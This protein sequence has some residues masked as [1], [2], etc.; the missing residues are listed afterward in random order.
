VTL[1]C[2]LHVLLGL[3]EHRNYEWF[4]T[5][6][7][8]EGIFCLVYIIDSMIV[9]TFIGKQRW[10]KHDSWIFILAILMLIDIVVCTF[11]PSIHYPFLRFLRPAFFAA[12]RRHI[13]SC[14]SSMV[15]AGFE[16]MPLLGILTFLVITFAVIGWITFDST[17][18]PYTDL[19]HDSN[20]TNLCYTANHG[21]GNTML[22]NHT[23]VTG[24]CND[25]FLTMSSSLYQVWILLMKVNMPDIMTPYYHVS[26]SSSSYFVVFTVFTQFFFL[27]LILAA[28]FT[29]YK[30]DYE[31]R[32]RRRLA[33]KNVAILKAFTLLSKHSHVEQPY[34]ATPGQNMRKKGSTTSPPANA[35]GQTPD[36]TEL[37]V[38]AESPEVVTKEET[39]IVKQPRGRRGLK[40]LS[41]MLL[42][43]PSLHSIDDY[44]DTSFIS[45][46]AWITTMEII[47][48][49]LKGFPWIYVLMF[50]SALTD[51][52]NIDHRET[53]NFK[54]FCEACHSI[55]LKVKKTIVASSTRHKS[56]KIIVLT[57]FG[58]FLLQCRKVCSHLVSKTSFEVVIQ[59]L[60]A[61]LGIATIICNSSKTSASDQVVRALEGA[62]C[63]LFFTSVMVRCIGHSKFWSSRTNKF[64]FLLMLTICSFFCIG[65]LGLFTNELTRENFNST[66]SLL[67]LL[68]V[69]RTITF[70]KFHPDVMSTITTIKVRET[71]PRFTQGAGL[72]TNFFT[73]PPTMQLILPMLARIGVVFM[74]VMYAFIMVGTSLFENSLV[75][76]PILDDTPYSQF[77]YD[78]LNFS[79]FL[80]TL[81]LLHQCLLGPNF[82]VFVEATALANG[83]WTFPLIY[84]ISYYVIVVVIVQ[85]IVV[86]FILEA[87]ISQRNKRGRIKIREDI[88][89][90][91]SRRAS[92]ASAT[93]P[94]SPVQKKWMNQMYKALNAVLHGKNRSDAIN[95]S[96][97]KIGDTVIFSFERKPPHHELYDSIF[98]GDELNPARV[99]IKLGITGSGAYHA[100]IGVNDLGR[101]TE[102]S[103]DVVESDE[104]A[105]GGSY[106]QNANDLGIDDIEGAFGEGG[107]LYN[108]GGSGG[109]RSREGSSTMPAK[110]FKLYDITDGTTVDDIEVSSGDLDQVQ[111]LSARVLEL[112]ANEKRLQES[113]R[114]VLS[115]KN[116]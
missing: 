46:S 17:Q 44:N 29:N 57:L 110:D 8:I 16:C 87:Y 99:T 58:R 30:N 42:S 72:L 21:D 67:Y 37:G 45:L 97:T 9:L 96:Q 101:R 69:L 106:A 24:T 83:D 100:E 82:P 43:D 3:I 94:L 74:C 11:S 108:S 102:L 77:H 79:S 20:G 115:R 104:F 103:Q 75:D 19:R 60:N 65:G 53:L 78:D 111:I 52:K 5:D 40:R 73:T 47:R 18:S 23:L 64:E 109:T 1:I 59:F 71:R 105:Q 7:F 14:F 38:P 84:F 2:L 51:Q 70:V 62:V 27:R 86:A 68:V 50:K 10:L 22:Y 98:H 31:H 12:R 33:F 49:D 35:I 15:K 113:L 85:N 55:N 66:I 63:V 107:A 26:A 95:L 36:N 88:V 13:K 25:Y 32:H 116:V 91:R 28:S 61:G 34:L 114:N 56:S 89:N 81:L 54:E 48:P 90:T 92:S 80:S 6:W 76:N 39:D 4:V 112:E 41:G 93:S